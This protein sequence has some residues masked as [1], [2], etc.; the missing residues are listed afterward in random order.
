MAV[1]NKMEPSYAKLFV[2]Y[3]EHQFFNQYNGSKP[4][5]YQ[6][7]YIDVCVGATPSTREGS[8]SI[9]TYC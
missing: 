7:R 8:Q 5:L 6:S 1:G 2:V 3:I 9:Y 4:E